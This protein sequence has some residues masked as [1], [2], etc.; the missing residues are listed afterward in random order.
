MAHFTS[1]GR[2]TACRHENSWVMTG[3]A[4]TGIA[5]AIGNAVYHATGTRVR[6]LPISIER[7]LG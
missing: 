4:I 1:N 3:L 7:V 2:A 6:S 5:A